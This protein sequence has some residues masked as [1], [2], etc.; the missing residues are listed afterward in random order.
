VD[1]RLKIVFGVTFN[2]DKPALGLLL[3]QHGKAGIVFQPVK[4]WRRR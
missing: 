1:A 4:R 3:W 2:N